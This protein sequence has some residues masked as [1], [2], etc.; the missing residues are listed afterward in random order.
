VSDAKREALAA[1]CHEQWSGWMSYL[2]ESSHNDLEGSTIVPAALTARWLRQI[3]TPYDQLSEAEKDS[4]RK[5]ADRILECIEKTEA[6]EARIRP[7][8]DFF[9]LEVR[10]EEIREGEPPWPCDRCDEDTTE[11]TGLRWIS[12]SGDRDIGAVLCRACRAPAIHDVLERGQSVVA[13]VEGEWRAV[14]N[15]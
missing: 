4:D 6:E 5:E 1:L 2:F 10:P 13:R 7:Y 15:P 11:P 3:D 8:D 9:R 14:E 12:R